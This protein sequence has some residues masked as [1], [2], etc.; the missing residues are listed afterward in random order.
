M[1]PSKIAPEDKHLSESVDAALIE[2]VRS[3][4]ADIV[5]ATK[6]SLGAFAVRYAADGVRTVAQDHLNFITR[7]SRPEVVER[8]HALIP[9]LG[10]F[11]TLNEADA[12]D[13]RA[14]VPAGAAR[15]CAIPNAV[16]WPVVDAPASLSSKIVLA[17]G[18][19]GPQKG[20][21]RLVDAYAPLAV[22]HPD[23]QLHIYGSGQDEDEIRATIER[24]GIAGH[25]RLMGYTYDL[26]SVMQH[27]SIYAMTSVFEGF[28]MVLLEAMTVGLPMVAYDCPRG[29]A[30]IIRDGV[31]GRLISD[32]A[33][34][35]YTSALRGLMDDEDDRLRM[36][37]ASWN[38]AHAYETPRIVERWN[39]LFAE[40]MDER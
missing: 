16:S 11:V 32:G 19:L 34:D 23:W 37:R 30:E 3:I 25:V 31:N 4:D 40:L 17:A 10:A 13:Y 5:V 29:P 27:G 33:T 6:P 28:P 7:T 12:R 35:E 15:I 2:A 9:R 18:R 24:H 38:D 14:L 26:R 20:F 8:M 22:S 1:R 21:P 36:G 39:A